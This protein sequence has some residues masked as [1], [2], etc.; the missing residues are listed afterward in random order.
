MFPCTAVL[1]TMTNGLRVV[2]FYNDQHWLKS[3]TFCTQLLSCV[4]LNL[5]VTWA[6]SRTETGWQRPKIFGFELGF[7]LVFLQGV[8]WRVIKFVQSWKDWFTE[9]KS[10]GEVSCNCLDVME[11][12]F[13]QTHQPTKSWKFW[14][15]LLVEFQISDATIRA[16]TCNVYPITVGYKFYSWKLKS[17]VLDLV[18]SFD[19][20]VLGHPVLYNWQSP[21]LK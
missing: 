6:Y 18:I 15:I 11:N 2:Q 12:G 21:H 3:I 10:L 1:I 9:N 7:F 19:R 20:L 17:L 4:W 16:L 5:I 8:N 13:C 14:I